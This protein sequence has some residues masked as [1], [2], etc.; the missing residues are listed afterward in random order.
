MPR[1]P[2]FDS[3]FFAM[4][5]PID[6][7]S[8]SKTQGRTCPVDNGEHMQAAQPDKCPVDHSVRSSWTGLAEQQRQASANASGSA[9][10][11]APAIAS[12]APNARTPLFL[13]SQRSK[14]T[15]SHVS[16][17]SITTTSSSQTSPSD[18]FPAEEHDTGCSAWLSTLWSL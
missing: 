6:H 10:V 13:I 14:R 11:P 17:R 12:N 15:R 18:A 4:S 1:R 3:C 16:P 9:P 7:S 8:S 2:S 5:C